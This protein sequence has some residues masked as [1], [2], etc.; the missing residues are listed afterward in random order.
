M[1]ASREFDP[2][3]SLSD[4]CSNVKLSRLRLFGCLQS[5]VVAVR[6]LLEVKLT[7]DANPAASKSFEWL[8]PYDRAMFTRASPASLLPRLLNDLVAAALRPAYGH[9]ATLPFG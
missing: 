7:L 8:T 6:L 5:V 9:N 3:H 4:V 1:D 2:T